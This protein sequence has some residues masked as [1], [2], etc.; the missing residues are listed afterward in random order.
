MAFRVPSESVQQL[1][2][3][4][5]SLVGDVPHLTEE[6]ER[7]F[8]F[9]QRVSYFNGSYRMGGNIKGGSSSIWSVTEQESFDA[10][11]GWRERDGIPAVPDRRAYNDLLDLLERA[12][13]TLRHPSEKGAAPYEDRYG[14]I[15][16]LTREVLSVLPWE[17]L[18]RSELA[19]LQLGGWG[20]DSAKASSYQDGMVMMYDFALKGARRTFIGLL[21]HEFGHAHAHTISVDDRS[22]IE[23]AFR[24]ISSRKALIGVEYLLDAQARIVYQRSSMEEFLAETYMLYVTHGKEL[25]RRIVDQGSQVQK[26][27]REVYDIFCEGFGGVEYA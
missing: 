27:W 19:F 11:V 18:A 12:Q 9:G 21:L 16:R 15:Y 26:A 3:P 13:V 1:R 5:R 4:W 7:E 23:K 2:H 14:N 24:R 22:R 20:P 8:R 25:A 10:Y 17:H 6:L